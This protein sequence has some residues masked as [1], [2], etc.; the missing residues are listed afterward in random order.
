[1]P[2]L[3]TFILAAV[4]IG[5]FWKFWSGFERTNFA[6]SL[7]NRIV[8]SLLWPVLVIVNRSYR[9]NFRKALKG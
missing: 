2:T 7:P 8:L 5:G 3:I 9:S 1:M 6:R 4:Y